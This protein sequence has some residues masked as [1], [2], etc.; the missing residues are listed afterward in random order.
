MSGTEGS[1]NSKNE[2]HINFSETVYID[3]PV[4]VFFQGPLPY[5]TEPQIEHIAPLL[6][7]SGDIPDDRAE[8][9]HNYTPIESWMLAHIYREINGWSIKRTADRFAGER[10]LPQMLGFF[11]EGPVKGDPGDPPSYTQLRDMWEENFTAR[12]RGAVKVVAERLVEYCRNNGI[13]RA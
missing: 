5:F 11:D 9:H 13:S 4:E 10:D 12:H 2:D 6:K 8:W 3:G 1:E 7:F